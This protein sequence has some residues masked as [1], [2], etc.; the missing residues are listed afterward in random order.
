MKKE[1]RALA[2]SLEVRT[3]EAGENIVSGYVVEFDKLSVDLGGFCEK[4]QAGAFANS[5]KNNK[6]IKALWGHDKNI[7]LGSTNGKTLELRE[8][9]KGLPFEIMLPNTTQG[10][11]YAESVRRGDVDGVSFGFSV[12]KDLW[13]DSN[14]ASIVRTLLEV[15]LFEIS[16]TAFPAYPSSSITI[17]SSDEVLSEY[18]Q[19]QESEF[20]KQETDLGLRLKIEKEKLKLKEREI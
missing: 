3:S 19:A 13:D 18:R 16:L 20:R 12:I 17:R 14:K 4:V 8:D 6:R 2:R 7:V 1:V 5:L 9:E 15:D 10:R 11:D